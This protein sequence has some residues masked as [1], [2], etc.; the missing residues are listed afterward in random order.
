MMNL[1]SLLR[2][3]PALLAAFYLSP[4]L[5]LGTYATGQVIIKL[6]KFESGGILFNSWEGEGERATYDSS[7]ECDDKKDECFIPKFETFNFSVREDNARVINFMRNNMQKEMVLVYKIHRVEPAALS[8]RFEVE[9]V[10]TRFDNP[11]TSLPFKKTAPLTG[12]RNFSLYGRVLKLEYQGV[13]VGTYEG[14]YYDR[15]KDKIH[16]FSVTNEAMALHIYEC[17]KYSKDFYIGISVAIVTGMRKSDHDVFEI[18][19]RESAGGVDP[20]QPEK[21]EKSDK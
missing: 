21:P 2:L 12:S 4:A 6:T 3:L 15:Q 11:P 10:L 9:D 18:N 13:T 7:E 17:M 1:R 14:L 5:A 8:T 19:Y 16:P 20:V